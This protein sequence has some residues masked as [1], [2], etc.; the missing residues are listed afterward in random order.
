MIFPSSILPLCA[1]LSNLLGDLIFLTPS[2]IFL[3][4]TQHLHLH[5]TFRLCFMTLSVLCTPLLCLPLP[6]TITLSLILFSVYFLLGDSQELATLLFSLAIS[7]NQQVVWVVP[8]FAMA[9][10]HKMFKG[11][12]RGGGLGMQEINQI[13]SLLSSNMIIALMLVVIP[14][15]KVAGVN[16][17]GISIAED[18]FLRIYLENFK[19]TREN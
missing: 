5:A 9:M 1:S 14:W 10:L 15:V 8:Q 17:N 3:S 11:N 19:G 7:M 13:I 12:N 16:E 4:L 6:T 18:S 2:L